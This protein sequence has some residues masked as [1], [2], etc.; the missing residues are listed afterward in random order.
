MYCGEVLRV[1]RIRTERYFGHGGAFLPECIYFWG[2][3][4]SESYGWTP[5]EERG[6]DKLQ[7]SGYHK[8]EWVSG[9][10]LVWLLLEHYDYTRDEDALKEWLL[11]TAREVLRFFDLH[12]DVG[13]DGKLVM[14]P[15][16]ALETWWDTTNPMPE[17]AG[18]H[19]VTARLLALPDRLTDSED[20][21]CWRSL[22]AKL[23]ELPTREVDGVRMLAPAERFEMKRNIENPELYAVFPFRLIAFN[24]PGEELGIQALRHRWDRGSSGWRQD[25]IFMAYLGLTDEARANGVSRARASDPRSRFPA[26]W[27][28][29]Y[30]W[31]PDQDHGSVLVK[32]LQS[33]VLQTDGDKLLLL[34]AWPPEWDLDFRLHAPGQTVLEGRVRE[35]RLVGLKVQPESRRHDVSHASRWDEG[36]PDGSADSPPRR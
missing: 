32:A 13:P 12:Y 11:P 25:D 21:E 8:W 6:E 23:P 35:G 5:F 26:F 17:L 20:L 14:H 10:E 30:D 3:V 31:V 28:P 33:M 36:D 16:Q 1:S 4:F 9:P 34:P 15:S 29:N 18:L 27:G 7:V 2:A 19:A 22:L 24:R